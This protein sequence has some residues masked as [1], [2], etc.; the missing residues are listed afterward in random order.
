MS[1]LRRVVFDTSSLIGAAL[2]VGSVPHRALAHALS[3]GDVCASA[4]TL[5]ELEQVLLRPKF[6]RYQLRDI[7]MEFAALLRQ[8]IH[9]LDVSE[10]DEANVQ[11]PCRDP[12]D[13]KFLALSNVCEADALISSDA[14][15]LVLHP[16]QG[17]QILT[18]AAFVAL[19]QT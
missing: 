16:W 12:K 19:A 9:F 8:Q 13:N 15:L 5:A 11:P 1:A 4:A 6:D 3:A 7:R 14:D 10:A 17:V 18:P 2:Q